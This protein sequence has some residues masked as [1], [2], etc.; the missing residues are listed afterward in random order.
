MQVVENQYRIVGNQVF[1]KADVIK[2]MRMVKI[3]FQKVHRQEDQD[4]LR[5]LENVRLNKTTPENL[6]HLNER[7]CQPTKEDGTV[8]TLASLNRLLMTSIRSV[9]LRLILRSIP[10]RVLS[11]ASSRRSASLWTRL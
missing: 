2:R 9:W 4:F 10:T 11:L 8:I 5:I 6:M 3:E 1:N 7:V